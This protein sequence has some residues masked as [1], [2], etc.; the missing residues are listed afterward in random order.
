MTFRVYVSQ[1]SLQVNAY[2]AVFIACLRVSEK[3]AKNWKD[4]FAV[5]CLRV[6]MLYLSQVIF[7]VTLLL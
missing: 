6:M 5:W 2:L 7:T 3:C 1:K 4:I